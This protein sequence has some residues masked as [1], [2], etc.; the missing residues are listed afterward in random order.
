MTVF[1]A[2]TS[3]STIFI[4]TGGYDTRGG[5]EGSQI[6]SGVYVDHHSRAML[7]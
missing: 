6:S 1:T 2:D 4:T 3:S 7:I 5:D